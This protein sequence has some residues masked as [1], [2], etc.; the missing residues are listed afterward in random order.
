[1]W[2]FIKERSRFSKRSSTFIHAL[3]PTAWHCPSLLSKDSFVWDIGDDRHCI[4]TLSLQTETLTHTCTHNE[5][6]KS[7]FVCV[8]RSA[9]LWRWCF[10]GFRPLVDADFSSVTVLRA[11]ILLVRSQ[12]EQTSLSSAAK[13]VTRRIQHQ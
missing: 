13:Q 11:H 9:A 10:C 1:M 2:W 5:P 6:D 8:W 3:C 4:T 7:F 12:L